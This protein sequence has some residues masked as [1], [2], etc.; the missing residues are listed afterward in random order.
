MAR[1]RIKTKLSEDTGDLL[2]SCQRRL[3][4]FWVELD[5]FTGRHYA[6]AFI[7]K[8]IKA[9]TYKGVTIKEYK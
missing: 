9:E 2:Y 8:R 1:Y 7:D 3:L 6:E 5:Y 4:F